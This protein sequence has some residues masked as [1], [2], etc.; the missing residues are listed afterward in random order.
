MVKGGDPG[1]Q[2][3]VE[4]SCSLTFQR[5]QITAPAAAELASHCG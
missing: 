1:V 3:L 2:F 4:E 5:V